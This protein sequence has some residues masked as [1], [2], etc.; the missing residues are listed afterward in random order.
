MLIASG[1]QGLD[2]PPEAASKESVIS[3]LSSA[4]AA[5]MLNETITSAPAAFTALI[6]LATPVGRIAG[7]WLCLE[8]TG[9]T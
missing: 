4:V 5:G 2:V 1:T 6:W 9:S 3:P 7:S 8:T